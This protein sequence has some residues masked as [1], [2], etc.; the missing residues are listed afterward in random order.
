M[1]N[2]FTAVPKL[3]SFYFAANSYSKYI[4]EIKRL[5]EAGDIEG[6]KEAIRRGQKAVIERMAP[7]LGLTFEVTGEENIPANDMTYM[8]YSNHQSFADVLAMIWL[9]K[10]RRQ[11]GYVAKEEWRKYKVL[12]NAIEYTRSVF[13]KRGDSRE[14]VKSLKQV[15]ELL[16]L[17]FALVIFP[18]GTRSQCHEMGEFKAGAFKFAEKAK[19]PILPVTLDG[20]YHFF[21]E[22]GTYQPAHIKVTIHPLVHIEDMDKHAQK[23]AQANIEKMIRGALD[24]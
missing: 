22:L 6:E 8:V 15:T 20:G 14:A 12:Y 11:M 5:R 19:V 23:E 2:P 3:L 10:D 16:K 7:K 24:R 1:L 13:L 17:G 4:P 9:F 18:E 21:E